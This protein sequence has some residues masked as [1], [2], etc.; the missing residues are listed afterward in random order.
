M[1]RTRQFFTLLTWKCASRHN[2]LH[3][4][5]ISTSKSG[6]TLVCFVHFDL[7]MYFPPPRRAI[8]LISHL[9]SWLHTRHFSEPTFRP[10]R[11]TNHWKKS[12]DS[13]LSYLFAHLPLLSSLSFSFL[14]YSLLFFSSLTLTLSDSSHLCFSICAYCRKFDF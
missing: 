8:F 3:F 7:D 5:D 1:V 6:P 4:F 12:S 11:A 9:A 13:R 14:I 2:T 10:S